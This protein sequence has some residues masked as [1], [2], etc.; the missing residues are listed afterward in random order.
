MLIGT[1]SELNLNKADNK[2]HVPLVMFHRAVELKTEPVRTVSFGEDAPIESM[3]GK[4]ESFRWTP[5]MENLSAFDKMKECPGEELLVALLETVKNQI[6]NTCHDNH[7]VQVYLLNA[8]LS[9]QELSFGFATQDFSEI[10]GLK[11]LGS[12]VQAAKSLLDVWLRL[13]PENYLGA[14]II[15]F[16]QL[17]RA[18]MDLLK[19][20]TLEH[21]EWAKGHVQSIADIRQYID[22]AVSN[23]QAAAKP[24]SDIP[25][26]NMFEQTAKLFISLKRK[27]EPLLVEPWHAS[28]NNDALLFHSKQIATSTH[29]C[30]KGDKTNLQDNYTIWGLNGLR[31]LPDQLR[32]SP[33]K[34]NPSTIDCIF[35]QTL[36]EWLAD[37]TV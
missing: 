5:W 32:C 36:G 15:S 33:I 26:E 21:L 30:G 10:D 16:F 3:L 6:S 23:F 19:L 28:P 1:V 2:G 11:A 4:G 24:S 20:S 14:S 12:G 27:W 37:N 8:E 35:G 34:V 18:L 9:I 31:V 29:G 25:E 13:P 17:N 22:A 7:V